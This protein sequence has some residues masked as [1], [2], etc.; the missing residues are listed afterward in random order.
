MSEDADSCHDLFCG[1]DV[2]S[3]ERGGLTVERVGTDDGPTLGRLGRSIF[4]M[5]VR[6]ATA[7]AMAIR[8]ATAARRNTDL[9]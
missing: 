3:D 9:A 1:R 2:V 7:T 8:I 4:V 6:P 5:A